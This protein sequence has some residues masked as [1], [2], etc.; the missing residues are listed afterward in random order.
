MKII[1]LC[2]QKTSFLKSHTSEGWLSSLGENIMTRVLVLFWDLV[3]Y[4]F[5]VQSLAQVEPKQVYSVKIKF[6]LIS[7]TAQLQAVTTETVPRTESHKRSFLFIC[8]FWTAPSGVT[9]IVSILSSFKQGGF[10]QFHL[11]LNLILTCFN[12]KTWF[13]PQVF[14]LYFEHYFSHDHN[15]QLRVTCKFAYSRYV[16]LEFSMRPGLSNLHQNDTKLCKRDEG[17]TIFT[18]SNILHA[19][20]EQ[21]NQEPSTQLYQKVIQAVLVCLT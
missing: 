5:K 12:Q 13:Y 17:L 20:K 7:N 8:Q 19:R 6:Q 2:N 11:I 18:T 3:A 10:Y 9:T 16:A 4:S 14:L 15:S 21:I 1:T